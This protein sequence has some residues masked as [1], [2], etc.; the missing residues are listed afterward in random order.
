LKVW[1]ENWPPISLQLKTGLHEQQKQIRLSL[2][3]NEQMVS[4]IITTD[5]IFAVLV[6]GA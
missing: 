5:L 3:K 6:N 2:E 4:E 1:T